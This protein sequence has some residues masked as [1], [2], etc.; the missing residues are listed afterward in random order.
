MTKFAPQ[1]IKIL[2]LPS[3]PLEARRSISNCPAIYFVLEEQQIIYIGRSGNLNKRWRNH[4][5]ISLFKQEAKNISIAWLKCSNL[6]LLPGIEVALILFFKPKF[7]QVLPES[8]NKLAQLRIGVSL[9]QRQLA[10]AVG[11][12]VQTISN[13]EQGVSP[14]TLSPRQALTLCQTLQCSLDDLADALDTDEET[15]E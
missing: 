13:W 14:V 7:N 12:T 3:L 1:S 15:E 11:I 6:E 2:E 8:R 10:K 4:E 5:K 9:T